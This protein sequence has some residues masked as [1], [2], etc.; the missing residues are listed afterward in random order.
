MFL[1]Q[2]IKAFMF[3]IRKNQN[4]NNE[5]I[6]VILSKTHKFH[7]MVNL[8][9]EKYTFCQKIPAVFQELNK[10]LRTWRSQSL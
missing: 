10:K 4:Y 5:N 7:K 9:L 8:E 6:G 1:R 3:L 2:I